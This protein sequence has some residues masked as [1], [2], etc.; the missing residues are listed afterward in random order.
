MHTKV[1]KINLFFFFLLS[2]PPL[3]FVSLCLPLF[4][5]CIIQQRSLSSYRLTP[6]W[7]ISEYQLFSVPNGLFLLCLLVISIFLLTHTRLLQCE[8]IAWSRAPKW[9]LWSILFAIT[10]L[11]LLSHKSPI[12]L[13]TVSPLRG[14]ATLD[15]FHAKT[16]FGSWPTLSFISESVTF[17]H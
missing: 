7:V 12:L 10:D 5:P 15:N 1:R 3:R 4:C 17:N 14:L 16:V 6:S 8:N 13:I 11:R 2:Q 9:Q